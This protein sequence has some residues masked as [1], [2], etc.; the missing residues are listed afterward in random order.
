MLDESLALYPATAENHLVQRTKTK[1]KGGPKEQDFLQ[2][3]PR[4]LS[5]NYLV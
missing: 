3:N 1:G 5:S 2:G 4:T